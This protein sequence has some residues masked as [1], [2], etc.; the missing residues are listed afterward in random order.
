M[1]KVPGADRR[2]KN[3]AARS[4]CM[5]GY[6]ESISTPVEVI[7]IVEV[8]NHLLFSWRSWVVGVTEDG[9]HEPEVSS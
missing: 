2:G 3:T 1:Y 8:W 4:M 9:R 7:A 6:N 5:R